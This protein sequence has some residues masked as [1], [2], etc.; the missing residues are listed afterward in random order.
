[1][2]RQP[3]QFRQNWISL[4]CYI[5]CCLDFASI[6]LSSVDCEGKICSHVVFNIWQNA[7]ENTWKIYT[8]QKWK[9]F[10]AIY[11]RYKTSNGGNM[12]EKHLKHSNVASKWIFRSKCDDETIIVYCVCTFSYSIPSHKILHNSIDLK[13]RCSGV[14]GL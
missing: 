2:C 1:M 8:V 13:R 5:F 14:V 11:P 6:L 12:H 7:L 4:L 10:P 3:L 9:W